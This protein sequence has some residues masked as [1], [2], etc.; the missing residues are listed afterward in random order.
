MDQWLNW[1]RGARVTCEVLRS[2]A[3]HLLDPLKVKYSNVFS[4]S[5]DE[6]KKVPL[7]Y[8]E[9]LNIRDPQLTSGRIAGPIAFI[10]KVI[11]FHNL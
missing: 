4:K 3:R 6:Q 9:L 11:T 5:L 2:K 8:S 10:F 1:G 7:V